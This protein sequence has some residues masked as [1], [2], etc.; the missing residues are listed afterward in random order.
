[1][2]DLLLYIRSTIYLSTKIVQ[3]NLIIIDIVYYNLSL[4]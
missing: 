4:A 1:M 2:I 3:T